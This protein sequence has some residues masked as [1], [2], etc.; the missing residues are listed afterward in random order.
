MRIGVLGVNF[1]SADI[2]IRE[3]VSRACQEQLSSLNEVA[4]AYT[5]VILS[6]C[7]RVEIYFS[8]PD[9]AAAHSEILNALK[10]E[11]SFA[12]EHRMYSYFGGDCFLHLAQV[13]AGMDSA[14]LAE[15]EI[16]GQ[17]K[18]AY[19][20]AASQYK[21]PSVLHYLFQ[22]SLQMGKYIRS[23][24]SLSQNQVTIPK[25]LFEISARRFNELE[26]MPILFIGN[27]E[28]N[29]SII[30][31][32]KSKGLSRMT[33]CS[34]SLSKE[35][36]KVS[37]LSWDNLSSWIDFPLVICGSNSPQH[38]ITEVPKRAASKFIIDLS[39][40]RMVD[41]AVARCS[42][43]TLLNMEELI[44]LIGIRQ[45]RNEDEMSKAQGLLLVNIHKYVDAFSTKEKRVHA[46]A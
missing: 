34:R 45:Q 24:F 9:L 14:I 18:C 38:L 22:K 36:S 16:Q 30:S 15:S 2:A 4:D 8:A 17:V 33:L 35:D 40:P 27:S 12:F 10:G 42:A 11:I 26:K 23:H 37:L 32:F 6:T 13:T 29:R 25:I 7:N 41:P 1:K 46:W 31:Y 28:I 39:V 21:L 20:R 3:G 5:C 19:E 44:H 43:V